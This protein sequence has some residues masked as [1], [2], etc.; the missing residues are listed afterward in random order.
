M[1]MKVP[2]SD[3]FAKTINLNFERRIEKQF[4]SDLLM[5]AEYVPNR[6]TGT[7]STDID[8]TFILMKFGVSFRNHL[9]LHPSKC[10]DP[11]I[12]PNMLKNLVLF[13]GQQE[14]F[15]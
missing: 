2:G 7:S 5:E 10:F 1:M 13:Y 8:F 12:I 3:Y 11:E 6:E 4:Q 14:F 9:I 15:R